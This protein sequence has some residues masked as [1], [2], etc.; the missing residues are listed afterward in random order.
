MVSLTPLRQGLYVL[1]RDGDLVIL[2]FLV[3]GGGIRHS[4]LV[5]CDLDC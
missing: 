5:P 4:L 2:P 3:L 1:H